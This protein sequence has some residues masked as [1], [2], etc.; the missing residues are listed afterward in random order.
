[1]KIKTKLFIGIGVLFTLITVLS[2]G[3]TY[4]INALSEDTNNILVANYNTLDYSRQMLIAL[5]K[6]PNDSVAV[7]KFDENLTKQS[8]NITENGEREETE[9]LRQN[10]DELL[11]KP[12]TAHF[13]EVRDNIH[14]LMRLNM[15]AII[16]KSNKAS[17]TAN[18]ASIWIA[19]TGTLCFLIA[20]TLLINFPRSIANPIKVLADS[21]K[22]I[23]N[24]NY[25]QRVNFEEHDEFGDVAAAFNMMAAKLKEY[26]SS[27]LSQLLFEKKRIETLIN[28]MHDPIIGLDEEKKVLFA[29]EEALDILSL[30]QEDILGKLAQDIALTNDL[31]RTLIKDIFIKNEKEV[32]NEPLKIFASNKESYFEK[33]IIN[34]TS[35]PT[36]EKENKL[37]GYVILLR[38]ITP[39][40]ELDA[41]KTNFIGTISHELKTPISS[42]LMS[43]NLLQN[44]K[45]G[46][47]NDEQKQLINNI[48]D[49]T[50][51]ILKITS[52]LLNITQVETGRIQ[53]NMEP[54]SPKEIIDTAVSATKTM[55]EQKSMTLVVECPDGIG[56]FLADKDK[57]TWVITNFISNAIRYS[58]PNSKIIIA[59]IQKDTFIE[60]AVQDFGKG[61]DTRYQDK[62]FDRYFRVPGNEIDGAGLGLAISKEFVEAQNGTIHV[63]SEVGIGSTFSVNLNRVIQ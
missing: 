58:H 33:E 43:L 45:I 2:V 6:L 28:K 32:R 18:H 4:Y 25:N 24:K 41:L 44:N 12:D 15:D 3:S 5:E 62:I 10:F 35:I 20:F 46:E 17:E 59:A 19:L 14:E 57:I 9:A 53:M 51:R 7:R 42:I 38:N 49:D 1:M 47:T 30:K 39:F 31:L 63:R 60:L 55:A 27:N 23:S 61:I 50:D 26:E 21:I 54:V 29:N 48:K 22:E 40:K 11:V 36:G 56:Y 52:E 37:V 13:S 16:R 8:K 34:I